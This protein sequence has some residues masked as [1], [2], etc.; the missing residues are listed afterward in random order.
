MIEDGG[1]GI[2]LYTRVEALVALPQTPGRHPVAVVIHGSHPSC[3]DATRDQLITSEAL[4]TPWPEGCGSKR[5]I[6][7][8]A[9]TQGPDYL[10]TPASMA[11]LA[12]ALVALATHI[13]TLHGGGS[14]EI[15]PVNP[16][17]TPGCRPAA[18]LA[19]PTQRAQLAQL[20]ADF[21][22][23]ALRGDSAYILHT[24]PGA[25][26]SATSQTTA[27]TVAVAASPGVPAQVDP[28]SVVYTRSPLRVLPPKPASLVL[29]GS[30]RDVV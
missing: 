17:T 24:V 27:A 14:N 4:T 25:S 15:G 13:G 8:Q 20:T 28:K 12:R 10:R 23:Q 9:I 2:K 3:I 1:P 30:N 29:F 19:K 11:Y 21:L 26:L 5:S 6:N 22:S 18:L 16:P 7:D